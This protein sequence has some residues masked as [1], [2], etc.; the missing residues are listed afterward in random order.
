MR[1]LIVE[2]ERD[3][4]DALRR[5]LEEEGYAVDTAQDGAEGLH[6]A[7]SWEYDAVVLDLMLPKLDGRAVLT[8]LREAKS[9]PVLVLTARDAIQDKVALLDLGADDYLTKPFAL[10]ELLARLRSLIRRGN[11]DPRPKLQVGEVVVDTVA[12]VVRLGDQIVPFSAKEYALVEFLVV[13]RGELVTRTMIYEHLYDESDDSLSNVLDVYVSR[14][15]K[16]LGND[17]VRTR[18]GEGYIVDA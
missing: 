18:R 7:R 17:F 8:R 5:A 3:L 13:H 15:R 12:R 4:A 14:I 2:D 16:R 1:V 6:K 11:S 10:G 9:T